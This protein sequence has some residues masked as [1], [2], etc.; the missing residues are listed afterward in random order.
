[1]LVM[2]NTAPH[3]TEPHSVANGASDLLTQVFGERGIHARSVVGAAQLPFGACIEV[4]M[5]AAR[6]LI[7][8][9]ST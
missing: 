1:M 2:V 8:G 3:F 7:R 5:I 9:D 6:Y 4:E